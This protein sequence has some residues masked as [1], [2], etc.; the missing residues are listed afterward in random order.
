[1]QKPKS[2]KYVIYDEEVIYAV[3]AHGVVPGPAEM[4]AGARNDGCG[5]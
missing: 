2:L 1:L 4:K 5:L 3:A